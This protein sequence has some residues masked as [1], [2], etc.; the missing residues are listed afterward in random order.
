MIGNSS[1]VVRKYFRNIQSMHYFNK[2]AVSITKDRVTIREE[3][4]Y[5]E[6]PEKSIC[7]F[8]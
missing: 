4:G 2:K 7:F 5:N 1:D 3:S 8:T 6:E